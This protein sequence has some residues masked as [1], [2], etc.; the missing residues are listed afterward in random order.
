MRLVVRH[1]LALA[2]VVASAGCGRLGYDPSTLPISSGDGGVDAA[3]LD[4]SIVGG[5]YTWRKS[6]RIPA[7]QIREPQVDMPVLVAWAA[8]SDLAAAARSDGSDIA[9]FTDSGEPLSHENERYDPVTGGLV[10][11]V[12]IPM[13]A[14][15]SDFLFYI[16]FGD[17]TGTAPEA[18]HDVYQGSYRGVWHLGTHGM[19]I[20][21]S[22]YATHGGL[23][24]PGAIAE[25]PFGPA[26]RVGAASGYGRIPDPADEHLD[27]GMGESLTVSLWVFVD[28]D[29]RDWQTIFEK[30]GLQSDEPGYGLEVDRIAARGI[31]GCMSNGADLIPCTSTIAL[32]LST[33]VHVVYVA[34]R[35]MNRL[36]L[37]VNGVERAV[38]DV[39]AVDINPGAG[40]THSVGI[41][42]TGDRLAIGLTGGVDELIIRAGVLSPERVTTEYENQR[43]AANFVVRGVVEPTR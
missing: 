11:W 25:G 3:M 31:Y 20:D 4:T 19:A 33:W 5:D 34:D 41:G 36:I 26:Q 21:S 38:N 7:E 23:T 29:V 32:P 40:N 37:Y 43:H 24:G 22:P 42:A 13:L 15:G 17:P 30:G 10:A 28:G 18:P 35:T 2:S 6:L 27:F 9:F 12:R 1:V 39:V 16:A 14:V 8:D